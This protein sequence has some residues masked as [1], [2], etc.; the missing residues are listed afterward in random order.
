MRAIKPFL[1]LVL[2]S[3]VNSC[4]IHSASLRGQNDK[5]LQQLDKEKD[6]LKRQNDP[7]DRAKTGIK[8]SEILLSL[9]SDAVRRG[10]LESMESRLDEYVTT[11][12]GAHQSMV[13]SGRD[14]RRRP[15]GFKELE[16]ALRR[17][18][19]QLDDLGQQ[20]TF[21]QREPLDKAKGQASDIRDDLLKALFGE[22]NAPSRKG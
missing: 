6:K 9:V 12:H 4:A 21:D 13:K 2:L 7:V 8:I 10:D 5:R 16:I 17:Q 11:I 22:Q 15:K 19:R 18:V 1:V 20:L 3:G 14:A